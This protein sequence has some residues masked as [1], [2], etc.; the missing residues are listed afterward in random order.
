MS[1]D[2]FSQNLSF[3]FIPQAKPFKLVLLCGFSILSFSLCIC[4][5]LFRWKL[6]LFVLPAAQA[7]PEWKLNLTQVWIGRR[8][9]QFSPHL[10][11]TFFSFFVVVVI[12][13]K[14]IMFSGGLGC[15]TASC[16]NVGPKSQNKNQRLV[17]ICRYPGVRH[18][19]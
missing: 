18:F 12:V 7:V 19:R 16:S 17:H 6:P 3:N 1:V 8:K 9:E 13:P 10:L 5:I 11:H 15:R 2:G 14:Y 4:T